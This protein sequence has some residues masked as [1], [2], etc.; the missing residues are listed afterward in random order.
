MMKKVAGTITSNSEYLRFD[1]PGTLSDAV[2]RIIE[3]NKEGD[4]N[5]KREIK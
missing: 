4:K 5:A 2:W 3:W 1:V